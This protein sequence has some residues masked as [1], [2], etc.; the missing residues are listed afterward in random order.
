[1]TPEQREFLARLSALNNQLLR[2]LCAE[3]DADSGLDE[4]RWS[5]ER[6]DALGDRMIELGRVVKE[7]ATTA[8][9][10]V[11]PETAPGDSGR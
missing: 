5:R 4:H 8:P 6:Q 9:A 7:R 10:P 1:M 2:F 3:L 11:D